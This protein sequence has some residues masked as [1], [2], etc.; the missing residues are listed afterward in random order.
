[1]DVG[2]FSPYELIDI[3]RR[4]MGGQVLTKFDSG[5]LKKNR[6]ESKE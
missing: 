6:D 4:K 5:V 3:D 2:Q 1:M